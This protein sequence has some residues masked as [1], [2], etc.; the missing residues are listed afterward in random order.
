MQSKRLVEVHAFQRVSF[1]HVCVSQLLLQ[2]LTPYVTKMG[3]SHAFGKQ[4]FVQSNLKGGVGGTYYRERGKNEVIKFGKRNCLKGTFYLYAVD[5]RTVVE[6]I[7]PSDSKLPREH[8]TVQVLLTGPATVEDAKAAK[9]L[10]RVR[11]DRVRKVLNFLQRFHTNQEVFGASNVSE[12]RIDALPVDGVQDHS[13]MHDGHV[14]VAEDTAGMDMDDIEDRLLA[15]IR[16]DG[17]KIMG[18]A[19]V[20]PEPVC[21]QSK[22]LKRLAR[23]RSWDAEGTRITELVPEGEGEFFFVN[24]CVDVRY[25]IIF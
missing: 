4:T 5:T 8:S 9:R 19:G 24:G 20:P 23:P 14:V 21:T 3:G 16:G 7:C 1:S 15:D 2:L 6:S 11:R 22:F 17:A 25:L 12:E 18:I 13:F 10:V